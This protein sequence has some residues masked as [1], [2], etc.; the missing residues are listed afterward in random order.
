MFLIYGY[1]FSKEYVVKQRAIIAT[2]HIDAHNTRITRE[3]L[4]GAAEDVN[5]GSRPIYTIEHDI[6]APPIG[7]VLEAWVEPR[8]DGEYQL[9]VTQELFEQTLWTTLEDGTKLF[10]QES[11]TDHLPFTDHYAEDSAGY[12]LSYDPVN[13]DSR[14]ESKSFINQVKAEAGVEFI[15]KEFGRKSA[16]PDAELVIKVAETIVAY[17][18]AK[19]VLDKVSDKIIDL[20]MDDV[21]QF[22]SFVKSITASAAQYI[23]PENRPITYVFV[24]S[25][26]PS[27]EF[28]ARSS[29]P[30]LVLS[31]IL[32]DKLE[33]QVVKAMDLHKRL[34]A[35]RIQYLLNKD[36]E[37]EFNYLLTATGAVVG[38][39]KAYTRR[40]RQIEML[41][42][43]SEQKNKK[44]RHGKEKK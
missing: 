9:V 24:V 29:D 4:E 1:S 11:E 12:E 31:A 30:D 37:W 32:L 7:K 10:K 35:T 38:T 2:T 40:T 14:A 39:E 5:K 23:R 36:G 27:I 8:N 20:A 18:V 43:Q 34:G 41:I 19:K 33:Q 17:L 25:K 26:D 16:I 6:T 22:Y 15:E 21:T 44:V 28:V 42:E 3:A 13:F